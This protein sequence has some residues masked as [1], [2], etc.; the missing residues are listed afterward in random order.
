MATCAYCGKTILFGG[1]Q[2]GEL[3]FCSAICHDAGHILVAAATVPESAAQNLAR[4]IHS[5]VCPRC[6][7]SGP[8]DVHDSYWI[9]SA[10]A[11]SRFASP[12]QVTC[13][14]CAF[15]S[16]V[17]NLV[18]SA[19]LGWWSAHGLLITPVYIVRNVIAIV[20]P[21]DPSEPSPKLVQVARVQLASQPKT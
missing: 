21:P 13:R 3:R 18:F 17:G 14:R 5:G 11:F 16:Q 15:T 6:Q 2:Q 10:L 19:I 4:E 8:V 9:W 7:G 1:V 12:Q 20:S